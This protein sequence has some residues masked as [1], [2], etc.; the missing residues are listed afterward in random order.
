MTGNIDD[1]GDHAD[2]QQRSGFAE[3]LS[4][5]D[6][7]AGQHAGQR[8]GQDMVEYRLDFRCPDP[9]A[10]SLME[11]GTDLSEAR[12]AMIMV[13]RVIR[14]KTSPPTSGV[15]RGIPKKLIK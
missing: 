7:S 2:H 3:G 13:G 4:H 14:V 5:A 12:P 1:K 6:D 9:R 8:Q 11:G 10:A 15:E